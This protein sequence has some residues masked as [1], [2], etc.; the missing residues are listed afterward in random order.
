MNL[1][2]WAPQNRRREETSQR[3]DEKAAAEPWG[4]RSQQQTGRRILGHKHLV[5]HP[6]NKEAVVFAVVEITSLG[7]RHQLD[8]L[9]LPKETE[10]QSANPSSHTRP[11]RTL[12]ARRPRAHLVIR[13]AAP[14]TNCS[15][16]AMA[17]PTPD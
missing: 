8:G 13:R 6:V 15:S 16:V 3:P 4:Q 7:Q 1:S 17:T 9:T 11:P 2:S 14:L 5:L 10:K 12:F